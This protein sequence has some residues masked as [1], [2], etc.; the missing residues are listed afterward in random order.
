MKGF[1]ENNKT[2]VQTILKPLFDYYRQREL[3]LVKM[4]YQRGVGVREMANELGVTTAA[5]SATY[6]KT[7]LL[8]GEL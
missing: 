6:P 7:K 4:L 2:E 5:V 8:K 3:K 1:M